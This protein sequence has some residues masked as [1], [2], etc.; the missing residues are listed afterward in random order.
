M[1]IQ[2]AGAVCYRE[3]P[4]GGLE[5][6]LISSRSGAWGIPKGGIKR[7]HSAAQ[8]A[9]LETLEEAGVLGAIV[10]PPLGSYSF[11]KKGSRHDVQVFA[12]RIDR[13]LERWAEE[14]QRTRVWV[15]LTEAPALLKRQA[16][17]SLLVQLRH[18]LLAGSLQLKRKAA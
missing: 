16:V 4:W 9:R 15:S 3:G 10:G 17:A 6:L 5:M 12:L 1:S 11:R 2:Q 8:T 13:Q 7:G 14:G 18:R